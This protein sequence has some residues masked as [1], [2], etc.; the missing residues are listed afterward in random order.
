MFTSFWTH[1]TSPKGLKIIHEH[2][3]KQKSTK[4]IAAITKYLLQFGKLKPNQIYIGQTGNIRAHIFSDQLLQTE[5]AE[6]MK[7]N[8]SQSMKAALGEKWFNSM[9]EKFR[10]PRYVLHDNNTE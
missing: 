6:S 1:V 7:H 8:L 3:K 4:E 9:K 2:A 5:W 10:I